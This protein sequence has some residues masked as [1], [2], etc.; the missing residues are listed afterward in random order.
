MLCAYNRPRY[1]LSV[2]RTIGPLV[3]QS[4]GRQREISRIS[5]RLNVFLHMNIIESRKE[6]M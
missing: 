6:H 1:Q 5:T 4:E 3:C 2:Y